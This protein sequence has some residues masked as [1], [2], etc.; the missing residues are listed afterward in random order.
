MNNKLKNDLLLLTAAMI[1]G[2]SFVAQKAGMEYIGP[3][4]FNGIRCL[5]GAL[6]LIP[7]VMF[8]NIQS[9]NKKSRSTGDDI[10]QDEKK[11]RRR[12]L[13]NGGAAC[14]T[15][16]F[17]ASSLQQVGMV[18]T[19]AGK[20]GFITTLYIVLVPILGA[21]LGRKVRPILWFCVLLSTIGLYLLC[22]KEDFSVSRGDLLMLASAFGFA[23]HILTID[24][25]SPKTD[26]VKMSCL[27]FFVCGLLS[28]PFMLIF[29]TV[30]WPSVF[31]CWL[32]ILYAGVISCGVA[33]TLQVIA[34]KNTEPTVASLLLS[35]ESVFALL[36]SMLILSEQIALKEAIGCIIMF[37]AILLAQLPAKPQ[38]HTGPRPP[39]ESQLTAK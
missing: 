38:L 1:W 20:S 17:I 23:A 35:L 26:G 39:A 14:G 16:L 10:T 31:A 15:V 11:S 32:P 37:A 5:I 21:L 13:F 8:L 9:E 29:E 30:E 4:T 27:Q 36:A 12:M 28:I 18:Y 24:Y 7:V 3:F 2:V 25:F 19:T 6:V 22:I 33:Y 34:Q